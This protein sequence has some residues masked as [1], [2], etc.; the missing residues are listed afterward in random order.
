MQVPS[1]GTIFDSKDEAYDFYNMFSW[2]GGFG[3][4]YGK[5]STNS[6]NYRTMQ[7]IVCRCAGKEERPNTTT[8]R[9]HC[10]ARIRLHRTDDHGW[11]VT[12]FINKHNHPLSVKCGEK[13]Q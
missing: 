2:E 10:E 8:F 5:S 4:C 13:K 6:K 12:V 11:Y 9:T 7:D 3:I 1:V